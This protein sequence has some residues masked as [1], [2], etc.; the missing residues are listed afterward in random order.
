MAR[1]ASALRQRRSCGQECAEVE[2]IV[3]GF[4]YETYEAPN[5][6][7]ARH[8]RAVTNVATISVL[9]CAAGFFDLQLA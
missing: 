6:L 1:S 9:T 7:N 5:F 2:A 8:S 4:A 3:S